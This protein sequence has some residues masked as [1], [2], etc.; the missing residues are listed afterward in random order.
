[1]IVRFDYN[2]ILKHGLQ[3]KIFY[4]LKHNHEII[5]LFDLFVSRHIILLILFVEYVL[6]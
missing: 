5:F 2:H 1:M 3:K 4:S 6:L